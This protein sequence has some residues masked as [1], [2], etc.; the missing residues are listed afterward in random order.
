M[1]LSKTI[2]KLTESEVIAKVS[3]IGTETVTFDLGVDFLSTTQEL[4]TTP[5]VTIINVQWSGEPGGI[6]KIDRGGTRIMSLLHDNGNY[7]D[8]CGTLFPP[9]SINDTDNIDVSIVDADG[10]A[11]QGELWLRLRKVDGFA[12]KIETAIFGI[13]DDLNAVG[14]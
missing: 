9:E 5:K 14:S 10:N 2:L 8:F 6:I 1:S 4:V 13:Y 12:S 7:M 11:V 3:G